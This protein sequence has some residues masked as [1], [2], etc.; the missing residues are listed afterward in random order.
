MLIALDRK[1]R[2][3][4]PAVRPPLTQPL[5]MAVFGGAF[6]NAILAAANAAGIVQSFATVSSVEALILASVIITLIWRIEKADVAPILLI[7]VAIFVSL[8]ISIENQTIYV[9]CLR[10]L[11]II[12]LFFMIGRRLP[13]VEIV[14]IFNVICFWVA[15]ILAIEIL[16]TP[17]YVAIFQPASYYLNTRGIEEFSVDT[18]G[19]F[20]NALGYEDRFSFGVFDHRTA[21]L[22]IDQVSL[23]NFAGVLCIYVLSLFEK[24][25]LK[26]KIFYAILIACI[27]ATNDSR[28]TFAFAVI[29]IAGYFVYPRLR[30][31]LAYMVGPSIV[32]CGAIEFLIFGDTGGDDF[33]GRIAITMNY[34][35]NLSL[36]EV[37]GLKI[38][39][40]SEYMDS[41]YAY[42]ISS[43]TG[44]GIV[45]VWLFCAGAIGE[46]S[47]SRRRCAFSLNLFIFLNL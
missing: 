46:G 15:A 28:T 9:D 39:R 22:F 11:A 21:S 35:Q 33:V 10:N 45:A 7:F 31:G 37:I 18:T 34:L 8:L 47:A 38:D 1:L 17:L 26:S 32:V 19:L 20:R 30:K 27:I 13:E 36:P 3:S 41:G 25:P 16:S 5:V 6:Y 23:A 4:V 40:I 43:M 2:S 14:F 42:V 44:L 24:L 29:S 12:G